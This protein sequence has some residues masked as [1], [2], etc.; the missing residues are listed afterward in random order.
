MA[1]NQFGDFI[2]LDSDPYSSNFVVPDPDP[3]HCQKNL[4]NLNT[5]ISIPIWFDKCLKPSKYFLK[6][7]RF[8]I[9]LTL[10]IRY[11]YCIMAPKNRYKNVNYQSFLASKKI[12]KKM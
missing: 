9:K 8:E 6:L 3:H 5:L 7:N 1:G 10:T 4:A 12:Y 11:N 2:H